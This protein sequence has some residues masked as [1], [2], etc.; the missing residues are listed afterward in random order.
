MKEIMIIQVDSISDL[1]TNSSTDIFAC[2]TGMTEKAIKE[3]LDKIAAA[4]GEESGCSVETKT[5]REF[6]EII[7]WYVAYD[8]GVD[9][10]NEIQIMKD[11]DEIFIT[12]LEKY[13]YKFGN[14]V[15]EKT[16]VVVITGIND[17]SIPYW[18][19]EFILNRL[20][21]LKYHL[22]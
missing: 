6:F 4:A 9:Y 3:L 16:K 14:K 15:S 5:M 7:K 1:I 2:Q 13:K 10:D 11:S 12:W 18:L 17:N 8:L 22:G 21:G 19:Q 20:N